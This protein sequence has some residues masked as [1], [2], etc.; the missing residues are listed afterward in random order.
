M[1]KLPHPCFDSCHGHYHRV[2]VP[3]AKQCNITC[4]YC[5]RKY[6]CPNESRPGVTAKLMDPHE[7][8]QHVQQYVRTHPEKCTTIGI[9]GPGDCLASFQETREFLQLMQTAPSTAKLNIC[10]ATNGLYLEQYT[11]ELIELGVTHV[12]VTINAASHQTFLNIYDHIAFNGT[13][14][15]SLDAFR[16]F[17]QTQLKGLK[18][19][20]SAGVQC[21]VNCVYIQ[22]INETDILDIAR[23]CSSVGVEYGNITRLILTEDSPF[24]AENVP[25][26][27]NLA[28]L[29]ALCSVYMHEIQHCRQCRADAAGALWEE[30]AL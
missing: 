14:S 8:F 24:S 19:L 15:N 25:S 5:N 30:T 11:S 18:K 4:K 21:K 29:R 28:T 26:E 17:Y 12:T 22:G 16:H 27:E 23:N 9:A 7:A 2:H 3:I 10:L 1:K 6:S 20:V 13:M